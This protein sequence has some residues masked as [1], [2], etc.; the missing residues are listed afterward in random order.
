MMLLGGQHS[1][2][3]AHPRSNAPGTEKQKI[4]EVEIEAGEMLSA[5]MRGGGLKG[6]VLWEVLSYTL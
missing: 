2:E 4:A 1:I 5:M 3:D 6:G